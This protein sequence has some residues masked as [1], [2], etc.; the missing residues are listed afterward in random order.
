MMKSLIA[1]EDE[2]RISSNAQ[3]KSKPLPQGHLRV[4]K[5]HHKKRQQHH[6]RQLEI[7]A[8]PLGRTVYYPDEV[9]SFGNCGK[10]GCCPDGTPRND[11]N[12]QCANHQSVN[13]EYIFTNPI[14]NG[15]WNYDTNKFEGQF[16]DWCND[17]TMDSTT[18]LPNFQG[19]GD[20]AAKNYCQSLNYG[21]AEWQVK[22]KMQVPNTYMM[23][24][25]NQGRNGKGPTPAGDY[26]Y[27]VKCIAK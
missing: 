19:C 12:D 10:P 9:R 20:E 8:D 25:N 4:V 21:R 24:M 26:I 13:G 15:N 14:M 1:N 17:Y 23:G 11:Y 22:S 27:Q 2:D 18:G 7:R 5:G 6:D 16:I 3:I